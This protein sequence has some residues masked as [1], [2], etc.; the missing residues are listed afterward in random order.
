MHFYTGGH[1]DYHKP[2]DD[3]DKINAEAGAKVVRL[4]YETA[5]GVAD[6]QQRFAFLESKATAATATT[7][8]FRVVMGLTPNYADD[9][10][11]GMLVDAVSVEGPAEVAGMKAHDRILRISGKQIANVYDYMAA[12][13]NNK[14]GDTVEVVVQRDDKEVTLQVTLAG[15]G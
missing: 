15:A 6:H 2:G 11:G 12:T 1:V 3:S 5:R 13:R 8:T 4:V 9:S 7:T 10:G 14:P